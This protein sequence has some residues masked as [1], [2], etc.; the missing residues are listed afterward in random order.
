MKK[1]LLLLFLLFP[2][3]ALALGGSF[4]LTDQ[5]GKIRSSDEFKGKYMLV[6]FGYT[7]CPDTCPVT[8][9]VMSEAMN[10][11]GEKSGKVQPVFITLDPKRDTP[12]RLKEY[13]VNFYPGF[14]ALTGE[15]SALEKVKK[16]YFVAAEQ[17]EGGKIGHSSYVYLMDKNGEYISHFGPQASS[18]EM[19]GK[20]KSIK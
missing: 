17:G 15:K 3:Q 5:N 10:E 7:R 6:F 13:M 9:A 2:A 16:N 18:E 12:A 19:A 8:L 20:I 1:L 11:L 4:T 14:V